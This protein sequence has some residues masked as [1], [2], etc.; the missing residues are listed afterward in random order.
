[1]RILGLY[2]KPRGFEYVLGELSKTGDQSPTFN[3]A[4]CDNRFGR[5]YDI[6]VGPDSEIYAYGWFNPDYNISLLVDYVYIAVA[7]CV[8]GVDIIIIWWEWKWGSWVLS[9]VSRCVS[10]WGQWR[11]IVISDKQ[12]IEITYGLEGSGHDFMICVS[13]LTKDNV[14]HKRIHQEKRE[15][16]WCQSSLGSTVHSPSGIWTSLPVGGG[17]NFW[18][19][20]SQIEGISVQIYIIIIT[21]YN[22]DFGLWILLGVS[23]SSGGGDGSRIYPVPFNPNPPTPVYDSWFKYV[24]VWFSEYREYR[25]DILLKLFFIL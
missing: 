3:Y 21:T 18:V 7:V 20:L 17:A 15:T 23:M 1:M 11:W 6:S 16:N 25:F 10:I 5:I 13:W 9:W 12:L 2:L 14:C 4:I 24:F 19:F 8:G 22:N